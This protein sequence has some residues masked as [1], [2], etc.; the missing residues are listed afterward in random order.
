MADTHSRNPHGRSPLLSL[1]RIFQEEPPAQGPD[2]L[3]AAGM[4]EGEES[5]LEA[6]NNAPQRGTSGISII[7][8]RAA[9]KSARDNPSYWK[10]RPVDQPE[11]PCPGC[12]KQGRFNSSLTVIASRDHRN[13]SSR[14]VRPLKSEAFDCHQNAVD[15]A[16]DRINCQTRLASIYLGL[17]RSLQI[18]VDGR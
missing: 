11:K 12:S 1:R 17:S 7:R 2:L 8:V 6:R 16:K 3:H 13:T 15:G 18:P 5:G 9:Q 10:A 4:P 14:R